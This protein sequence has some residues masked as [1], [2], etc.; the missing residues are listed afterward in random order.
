MAREVRAAW[1]VF[2]LLAGCD[3]GPADP[4]GDAGEG[5]GGVL[6]DAGEADSGEADAGDAGS[7]P[8][9]TTDAASDPDAEA[10]AVSFRYRDG[11]QRNGISVAQAV[12]EIAATVERRTNA[13]PTAEH[14]DAP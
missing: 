2:L 12:D 4:V 6:L 10:D 1:L 13:S 3:C 5:E 14:Y 9:A 8:D 11:T 7:D